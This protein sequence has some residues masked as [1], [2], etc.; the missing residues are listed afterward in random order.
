M[1]THWNV[2]YVRPRSEKKVVE[3]CCMLKLDY[4]LA[5]R[6]ETKIYQ[7]RKVTVE[8]PVFP[9]YVFVAF[10]REGRVNLLKSNHIVRI[11]EPPDESQ[12]LHELAQIKKALAVDPTLGA[13]SAVKKGITVRISAGPFMG[14]EGVV[15]SLKGT[16]KVRLNVELIGQAVVLEVDRDY[17]EVLD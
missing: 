6:R 5:L 10:D 11:L 8:K 7:R 14:V 3:H 13:S 9:G 1:D 4:Y 15:T 17:L 2:L 12:L 16:T